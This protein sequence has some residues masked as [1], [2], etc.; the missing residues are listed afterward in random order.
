MK[1]LY[2]SGVSMTAF[3]VTVFFG[4]GM[5]LQPGLSVAQSL[6]HA[7]RGRAKTGKRLSGLG[8]GR[9][10]WLGIVGRDGPLSFRHR[11]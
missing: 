11:F 6:L 5:V 10:R 8:F 2:G 7:Y 4:L 9:Y 3:S 1:A